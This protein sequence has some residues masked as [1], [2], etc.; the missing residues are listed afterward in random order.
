MYDLFFQRLD[1]TV[2]IEGVAIALFI[3]LVLALGKSKDTLECLATYRL[4]PLW[5]ILLHLLVV[6]AA[7]CLFAAWRDLLLTAVALPPT[8]IL[9]WI[10]VRLIAVRR[11]G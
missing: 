1:V 4:V 3:L 11:L 6:P 2:S 9:T 10:G 8:I 7:V 5:K